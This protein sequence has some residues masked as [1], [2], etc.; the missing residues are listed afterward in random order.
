MKH[1]ISLLSLLVP[2]V[3]AADF[4]T[5]NVGEPCT[6]IPALEAGMGSEP[7]EWHKLK[8]AE[9]FG[10]RAKAFNRQISLAY[11][12]V[13]GNRRA[14]K[15][16]TITTAGNPSSH[17]SSRLSASSAS[18]RLDRPAHQL[19]NG[20]LRRHALVQH[21]IDASQSGISTLI[22]SATA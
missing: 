12:C 11:F 7:I 21:P 6:S 20:I 1:V 13:D 10:F 17:T 4:R 16:V 18:L 15:A 8:G 3:E 5:L 14:A 19:A 22:R 9:V 2:A